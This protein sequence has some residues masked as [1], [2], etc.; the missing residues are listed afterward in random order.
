VPAGSVGGERTCA[1][2]VTLASAA[3][4]GASKKEGRAASGSGSEEFHPEC[5]PTTAGDLTVALGAY[6]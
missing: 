6:L 2:A 1:M 3:V 5:S 4:L